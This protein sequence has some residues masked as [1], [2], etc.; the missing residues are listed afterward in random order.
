MSIQLERNGDYRA[1]TIVKMKDGEGEGKVY[2][3]HLN[4]VEL[5]RDEDQEAVTSC[6]ALPGAKEGIDAPDDDL[7]DNQRRVL[8]AARDVADLC[9]E[10]SLRDVRNAAKD[11]MPKPAPGKNDNRLRDV[12][13]AYKALISLS[14]LVED[15]GSVRIVAG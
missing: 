10:S 15:S 7:T 13:R 1:A 5:G 3:F 8:Q 9:G 6:V 2:P 14:R 11:A 4:S 12:D